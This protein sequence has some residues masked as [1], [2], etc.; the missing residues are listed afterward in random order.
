M[1]ED[2]MG[3][4][5]ALDTGLYLI[6]RV[7]AGQCPS[8]GMWFFQQCNPLVLLRSIP[9]DQVLFIAAQI[10]FRGI[11]F[12]TVL[13]CYAVSF[14]CVLYSIICVQGWNDIWTLVYITILI[15]I[16][17]EFERWMRISFLRTLATRHEEKIKIEAIVAEQTSAMN[18][19]LNNHELYLI[20][21]ENEKK[22]AEA[23]NFQLR[24]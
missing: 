20:G 18:S 1:L 17:F 6:A 23:E 10:V 2:I 16:A 24:S 8:F 21:A 12:S 3:I 15:N 7:T 9:H 19:H 14:S 11:K 22:L 4:L 13:V 5:A